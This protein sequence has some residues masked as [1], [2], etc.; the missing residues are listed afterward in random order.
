M[1]PSHCTGADRPLSAAVRG[2]GGFSMA[3]KIKRKKEVSEEELEAQRKA[4][5]EE[6]AREQMGIEDEFQAK[7]FELMEWMGE[8]SSIVLGIIALVVVG[9][10]VTAGLRWMDSSANADASVAFTAAH[11]AYTGQVGDAP[12]AVTGAKEDAPKFK[13]AKER[14]EKAR[15]LFQAVVDE[16]GGTGAAELAQLYVGHTAMSLEDYDGAAAAYQG[17]LDAA[18]T[19]DA[20]APVALDGLA[21]ALEAKGDTSGAK[22]KLEALIALPGKMN[23]DLALVKVARMYQAEGDTDKARVA[24]ERVVNE[25]KESA[26]RAQAEELLAT[27]GSQG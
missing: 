2:A 16:H 17:Y 26:V 23:E 22:A 9:G 3:K 13:D 20:L 14:S 4:E 27:L 24:A 25:F 18:G 15:A 7:G 8:N 6:A 11:E 1:P 19:D 10:L 12:A 5:E 21:I